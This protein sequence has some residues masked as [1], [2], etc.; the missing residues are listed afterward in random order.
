MRFKFPSINV[1][2]G[3]LVAVLFVISAALLMLWL[4]GRFSAKIPSVNPANGAEAALAPNTTVVEAR[5][6]RLPLK[7][8]A[9]GTV[10]AQ[11]ETTVAARILARVVEI[12]LRAGQTVHQGELLVRMDATDLQARLEQSQAAAVSAAAERDQAI[13]DER[14]IAQLVKDHAVSQGDYD[15]AATTLKSAQ[16][17]VTRVSQSIVEA[18]AVLGYATIVAPMDGIVV[19]KNVD[20]GDTVTPG[21]PLLRLYDPQRMQL[22]ANVRESLARRLA[23]G[24]AIELNLEALD[25]TCVGQ[26]SEM[27]PD[28]QSASRT[29]QVKV[30]SPCLS[31]LY[32]GMFGRIFVPLDEQELLVIPKAAIRHVGQLEL[33]D[34]VD[35]NVIRRRAVRGGQTIGTDR[36]VLSGLQAGEKVVVPAPATTETTSTR[37]ASGVTL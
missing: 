16:A 1:L 17:N 14:R 24:Q 3:S 21:Q 34:V 8:S 4:A 29:F 7:E 25:K 35:G 6:L 2:R 20:V 18:Q 12:P 33:V 15:N 13:I 5:M 9:V 23:V 22:V 10:Q 11:H 31:G 32:T 36:E 30:T 19:D 37:S 26:V 28:S 27:V